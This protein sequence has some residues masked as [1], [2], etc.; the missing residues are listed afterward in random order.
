[1]KKLPHSFYLRPTLQ[2]AKD[3]LGKFIIRRYRGKELIGKI[4][5]VEAYRGSIDPA[6]HAYRGKTKRNEVMFGEGGHLY[7]YFTYGMHFCANVVTRGEGV[8]EAVLIRG[9]EPLEGIEVMQK[10]RRRHISLRDLTNG[11]AKFCQAFGI[12]GKEN[13]TNLLG[14]EIFLAYN[15]E[16]PSSRIAATTR[17]GI[18][19]ATDKRWRFFIKCND[20]VSRK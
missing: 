11:P 17:I 10:L 14:N 12:E 16:I 18:Q 1:L 15:D 6:S 7:V 4:V 3:L 19:A 2:V 13:G 9:V 5:E 20:W 8:A